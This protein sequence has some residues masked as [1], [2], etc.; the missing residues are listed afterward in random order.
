MAINVERMS[1]RARTLQYEGAV[2][3]ASTLGD[4]EA[5]CGHLLRLAEQ[6]TGSRARLVL[7]F[8]MEWAYSPQ[9]RPPA[10]IQLCSDAGLPPPSPSTA[11]GAVGGDPAAPAAADAASTAPAS[12]VSVPHDGHVCYLLHLASLGPDAHTRSPPALKQLLEHPRVR[13]ICASS[14]CLVRSCKSE[15]GWGC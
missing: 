12:C 14:C 1:G 3:Y 11:P 9:E 13:A 10:L 4:I 6:Q 2:V 7:G 15:V 5:A 8:D